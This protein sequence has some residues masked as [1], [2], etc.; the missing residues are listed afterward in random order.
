MNNLLKPFYATAAIWLIA[1]LIPVIS[2]AETVSISFS[3]TTAEGTAYMTWQIDKDLKKIRYSAFSGEWAGYKT[4]HWRVKTPTEGSWV[5]LY[6]HLGT[7]F[8]I[9]TE[10]T[11]VQVR[12]GKVDGSG[13]STYVEIYGD[14]VVSFSETDC[15]ASV[16]ITNPYGVPTWFKVNHSIDGELGRVLLQPGQVW[17]QEWEVSCGGEFYLAYQ[18]AGEKQ[19]DVWYVPEN[20]EDPGDPSEE[21]EDWQNGT[22]VPDAPPE[23]P[24]PETPPPPSPQE[25]DLPAKGK[26]PTEAWQPT[27]EPTEETDLLD[28]P[29]YRQGVD[30]IVKA[31][32]DNTEAMK[33]KADELQDLLKQDLGDMDEDPP[34]V[35]ATLSMP[36]NNDNHLF[37]ASP[38]TF[39][40]GTAGIQKTI[41]FTS[42]A[43]TALG[44]T[45]PSKTLVVDLE[46][47]DTTITYF[48]AFLSL[49]LWVIYWAAITRITVNMSK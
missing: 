29:T 39:F 48:R 16:N 3:G 4:F 45:F 27:P 31:V 32:R 26:A 25:A 23:E 47:H 30:K 24:T 21:P 14:E 42:P 13:S 1:V 28:R 34:E 18:P 33:E 44:R 40:E 46:E 17:A 15:K 5:Q 9:P 8:D 19:D 10:A 43:I 2:K 11:S 37:P 22:P 35:D 36:H 20:P 6:P 12:M 41:T 49:I 38:P 7:W